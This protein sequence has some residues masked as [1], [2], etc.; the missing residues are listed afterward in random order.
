M[1]PCGELRIN[2]KVLKYSTIKKMLKLNKTEAIFFLSKLFSFFSI[3][4]LTIIYYCPSPKTIINKKKKK[5]KPLIYINPSHCSVAVFTCFFVSTTRDN[6][7]ARNIF[8]YNIQSDTFNVRK[9]LF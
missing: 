2:N 1:L 9:L 8:S 4:L 6:T 5:R 7:S 3:E